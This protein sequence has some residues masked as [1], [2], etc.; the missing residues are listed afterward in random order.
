MGGIPV[1]LSTETQRCKLVDLTGTEE[2][3]QLMDYQVGKWVYLW[4]FMCLYIQ[5]CVYIYTHVCII[6]IYDVSWACIYLYIYIYDVPWAYDVS[7]MHV[8]PTV[9]GSGTLIA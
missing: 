9:T 5:T 6:Y 7:S 8:G 3:T 4:C 2:P 1:L